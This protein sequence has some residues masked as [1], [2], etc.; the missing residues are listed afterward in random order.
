MRGEI[1][2]QLAKGW[3]VLSIPTDREFSAYPVGLSGVESRVALDRDGVRHLLVTVDSPVDALAQAHGAN[4]N[5][6]A[7]WLSFDG[8]NQRVLDLSLG[9]PSLVREFDEVVADVLEE[10]VHADDVPGAVV[11]CVGRWRRL[12]RSAAIGGL[13]SSE[14]IGLYAELVVLQAAIESDIGPR[15]LDQWRGPLRESHDFEFDE[16]C[17]EVKGVGRSSSSV[18]I[19]GIDQLSTHDDRPLRLVLLTVAEAFDGLTIDDVVDDIR[20]SGVNSQLFDQRLAASGW[21]EGANREMFSV[22]A[23]RGVDVTGR[24]PRL[25]SSQIVGGAAPEGIH[26]LSYHLDLDELMRFATPMK[27]A[28]V[29]VS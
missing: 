29:M 9:E 4:L 22:G 8:L 12:F 15:A 28:E 3:A 18:V 2:A 11:A 27:L 23:I 26:R 6:V 21:I 16:Y 20:A 1:L 14:R 25:A 10:A 5:L 17:V 13:S 7:R 19:H 24:V